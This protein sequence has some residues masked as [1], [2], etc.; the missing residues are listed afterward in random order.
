MRKSY[1]VQAQTV[2]YDRCE[3]FLS[4]AH[5]EAIEGDRLSYVLAVLRDCYGDPRT[6]ALR[7]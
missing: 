3:P 1:R 4:P 5:R 7:G 6:G 2:L